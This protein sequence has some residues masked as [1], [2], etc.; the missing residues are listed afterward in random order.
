M[1]EKNP[2]EDLEQNFEKQYSDIHNS[3]QKLSI[4]LRNL[5]EKFDQE[6]M[7]FYVSDSWK[8]V[9]KKWINSYQDN[10]KIEQFNRK[11]SDLSK[12]MGQLENLTHDY[13]DEEFEIFESSNKAYLDKFNNDYLAEYEAKIIS[14]LKLDN[15]SS[16]LKFEPF[17]TEN[18]N[19]YFG[20]KTFPISRLPLDLNLGKIYHL[21]TKFCEYNNLD[22][23]FVGYGRPSPLSYFAHFSPN[24][25]RRYDMESRRRRYLFPQSNRFNSVSANQLFTFAT[26]INIKMMTGTGLRSA[27][28][29]IIRLL[30]MKYDI[31][32]FPEDSDLEEK[33]S[34]FLLN[35]EGLYDPNVNPGGRRS[36]KK[37]INEEIDLYIPAS[38]LLNDLSLFE[39]KELK[40]EN[41]SI[42]MN[43]TLY[44]HSFD[45][46][47]LNKF[48]EN[49]ILNP[50]KTFII[51]ENTNF[52]PN[53]VQDMDG[54][55]DLFNF[56]QN[57][58]KIVFGLGGS[59]TLDEKL[60]D[61][62]INWGLKLS[63]FTNRLIIPP[64][65][66][67][68]LPILKVLTELSNEYTLYAPSTNYSAKQIRE[69][70]L[71]Q[72]EIDSSNRIERDFNSAI[73]MLRRSGYIT[74]KDFNITEYGI[75][76][77]IQF[78]DVGE[79]NYLVIYHSN[80]RT[81]YLLDSEN[82]FYSTSLI[83]VDNTNTNKDFLVSLL[84]SEEIEDIK[85]PYRQLET[86][87]N[88]SKYVAKL[89][90]L[91]PY[92]KHINPNINESIKQIDKDYFIANES[93]RFLNKDFFESFN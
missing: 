30:R 46:S 48:Y 59:E 22:L 37:Q 1:K 24:S 56:N 19:R 73:S 76:E 66:H 64:I 14:Q 50:D 69:I 28:R 8:N 35:A 36:V 81:V 71:D 42:I 77:L 70:V 27:T 79:K 52:D 44:T 13:S 74:K 3:T 68:F 80:N 4:L 20:Y 2:F 88:I 40:S 34:E 60:K 32:T 58:Y 38:K 7:P 49:K 84:P 45:L 54:T 18:T 29:D 43:L 57:K 62:K 47:V 21:I 9:S 63:D 25:Y 65:F 12:K 16:Y 75:N 90:E 82:K 93:M 26:P 87:I 53:V 15:F 17:V 67:Y 92:I 23:I 55:N 83:N 91:L 33:I 51:F 72:M 31:T 78:I 89:V 86:D 61:S 85:S 10:N 6:L 39:A 41:K 11:I 5:L